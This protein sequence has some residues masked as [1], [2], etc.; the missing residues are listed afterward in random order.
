[1]QTRLSHNRGLLFL[2][3]VA[4]ISIYLSSAHAQVTITEI[5]PN[6]STLDA[7]DP[8]G[9][10][11]GRVNG[12]ASDP[13]NNRVF[14]AASEWG[15][16][17]KSTDGGLTWTRLNNHM[18]TVTWDVE[19]SPA[20]SN[21]IFATSFY[22][23]RVA[24]RS[25]IN[26]STDGG[27]TWTHPATS[28]PPAG[29]CLEAARR[30]EPAA[31]GISVDPSNPQNVYVGTNCGLAI[32]NDGGTTWRYVDP[33]PA[34]RADDIWDVTVH[35]GGIIDLCGDDG[36][37]R[38]VDGGATWTT[39]TGI[40]LPSGRCSIA[41][42][43]DES[44]VLFAVAGTSI[45]ESDNGGGTW[46]TSFVNPSRQGRI[47]FVV[48]NKRTGSAFDLWFGDVSLFRAGCITPASP[49][50]G[51]AAR[52]PGSG[53]WAGGFT[54]GAGAHDD[55][56]DIVFDTGASSDRCPRLMSSDG[57]VFF[58][59]GNSSPGCQTPAWEQ[60]NVTPHGLWL[61]G[62]SG[63]SRLGAIPEDLYF[64]CQ[65][66][67]SF[68]SI[69]AGAAAPTWNNRD[70]CDGFD[71]SSDGVRV[72]YTICC[73]FPGRGNRMF[74]RNP[75]MTGGGELNTYPAGNLPGF[76]FPDVTDRF[77]PNRQVL[78]TTSGIFI[79]NNIGASPVVW[80]QLGAATSPPSACAVRTAG[81]TANP[82][83]YVQ[84]DSCSGQQ[85]SRIWRFTGTVP[86]DTWQQVLPPGG[87]G[88]FGIFTVDSNDPNRLF[89]S[90]LN[91][92]TVHMITS[93]NG[94]ASWT[95]L[96]N[97]DTLMTGSGTF[98]YQN[99]RGSTNFTGFGGYPQP[100]LVAFDLN[101]SNSLL[102]GGA[103]SGIFLSTDN[104]ARWTVIT[105]NSG[106]SS[107][108]HIPRPR[109][110]YFDRQ[111]PIVNVYIGTQGRGVWR[112][113]YPFVG[114]APQIQVPSSV[115]FGST[116]TGTVGRATLNVCNTGS[117]NLF[118]NNITS[119]NARFAV[120]TPSGGYPV[121]IAPGSCFPFEATFTPA[122]AGPQTATLTVTSNDPTTPSLTVTAAAQGEAGSLGLSP[123]VQF[124]P[125]V[126]QN[127][128][129]CNTPRPF[130]ISNTGACNLT[131]TNVAIG[132]GN[133]GD[134][135]LSGLPAFPI[136]LQPGHEVG[137][138]DLN[139]VFA[140]TAL[141]RERTGNISVTFSD[142]TTGTTTTQTRDL[143]GEGVRTGARV[144]VT[145]GGVPMAQ[146]HEIELKRYWGAW[147]GFSKEVDEVKNVPLQ[148]V[149]ATPGTACGT[150]QFHR[151][152]GALSNE[153][154]LRP[155]IYQL[156][157]EVKIAGHKVE[158][159][160]WFNVDTCGFNGTIVV[161]F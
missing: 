28:V 2:V 60:P 157:V 33:T 100:T 48:T 46:N 49:A 129:S 95:T 160:V 77:G 94:G 22:D 37:R 108:P 59:T 135:S 57:G 87:G 21:R 9:A 126:I 42:S 114:S 131:I 148:A 41:A 39:A 72:G 50:P 155:G 106:G 125:T 103:D 119:S 118:V 24:S 86:G 142:P 67:G 6:Q 112:I 61:F 88:G 58:N 121:V 63:T 53:S 91:G 7:S 32:S 90:H 137:S 19:V 65:D 78:L 30:D 27:V 120:T 158:K 1:M 92:T 105:N 82:T 4:W 35:H 151:E 113:S 124:L 111:G 64:G 122:I 123:N 14:Y 45:F 69:D 147:F 97:L 109:Y 3:S 66:N 146:V 29:R 145:Q 150:F 10:S 51:G 38:S 5:N 98:R 20:D 138:G 134:F 143:C 56:G 110:A 84:G 140:P 127:L 99:T 154:Q 139:V 133:A 153:K 52:C 15:G 17:Y 96:V 136:I 81:P 55:T 156:E 26:V 107:N 149:T 12:L 8:D 79:T 80:T 152:Y 44:Y 104:G 62:L 71:D 40:A 115:I 43:P 132:G 89:A 83:F 76:N 16:L 116:C 23:G 34:N 25:G 101:D 36:H 117:A 47:P 73:F 144:L 93:N 141:A 161:D 54:R 74:V 128:G 75:G 130:V 85:S 13:N 159:K 31:F 102:A 11:G 70:C 68:A 18:P